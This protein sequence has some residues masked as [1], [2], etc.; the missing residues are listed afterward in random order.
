VSIQAALCALRVIKKVPDIVDHFVGK[1]KNLLTDR[2]HGVLLSCITLVTEMC[3][4]D[5]SVLDEFRYVFAWKHMELTRLRIGC[6]SSCQE[7]QVFSH[8]R[9]QSGTRCLGNH[10]SFSPGEDFT[11][12][13]D[14]REGRSTSER[15]YERYFSSGLSSIFFKL[16]STLN[17]CQKVATNTDAT[18]NVG[19]SILY[20]TVLTVLEIEA[21][22][23][24]RVM[25]IN[26][27]GKFLSNR[28]NNI[29]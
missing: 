9:L 10:R 29:R 15:Y 3:Q 1:A 11:T 23:G 12:P 24:L 17:G 27:L 21:D 25:A 26:I 14:A 18:K 2:N 7:S 22:T 28:D 20:E 5:P 13:P 4:I 8:D 19:N 16:Q 6:P